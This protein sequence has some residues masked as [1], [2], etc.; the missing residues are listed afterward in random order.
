VLASEPARGDVGV[1]A[2]VDG[3]VV[4]SPAELG[5]GLAVDVVVAAAVGDPVDGVVAAAVGDPVVPVV[6]SG[7]AAFVW[8]V[9]PGCALVRDGPVAPGPEA[10]APVV[11]H[12]LLRL[13]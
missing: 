3:G 4:E 9:A 1:G 11:G 10:V 13:A 2:V 6:A 5:A 8:P 7:A 12:V